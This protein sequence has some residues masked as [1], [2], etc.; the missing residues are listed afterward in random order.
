M[1]K[2][3][4]H[5]I[6]RLNPNAQ[7]GIKI[8]DVLKISG[9]PST[10]SSSSSETH[11]VKQKE[12]L[13]G[14]A[15]SHNLSVEELRELNPSVGEGLKTGQ[16]LIVRKRA[17]TTSAATHSTKTVKNSNSISHKVEARETKF[18]IAKQYGISVEEL[19]RQNPAIRQSLPVGY[20]LTIAGAKDTNEVI[21]DKYEV[22][23]TTIKQ[24]FANYEVKP[25]E[26]IYSLT[27]TLGISE[28]EL[29]RLN[30]SL[31]EGL[32][33]GMILKVPGKGSILVATSGKGFKDLSKSLS[34]D[35]RRK[36]AMLL[37]FNVSKI[38][39][40]S[41]KSVAE[42][43]KS[44]AFLNMTLDFYS[45]ALM[46]IDSAKT[47]GLKVDVHI[48]DSGESRASSNV[49]EVIRNNNINTFD[50]VIGPFYQEHAERAAQLLARD[51]V[52][53]ISP[54]S[55][56]KGESIS[57]LYQAMPPGDYSKTAIFE[58]MLSKGGNIVVVSAAKRESNREF[59][60]TNF[61]EAVFSPLDANGN[62]IPDKLKALL[63]K[64]KMNYVVLDSEKTG[65]ILSTTNV[66]LNELANYKIQL[67]I[68]EQNETLDF[69]EISMK[70]LTIL[71]MLYPSLIRE[72]TSHEALQFD[73][74]Y[75]RENKIFP[76]QYAI[77]GF[78]VTFDTLLRLSQEKSFEA[79][80]NE[81]QTEQI[82]SKFNYSKNGAEGYINKGVYILQFEEDLSVTEAK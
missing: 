1:Y 72:N 51:S 57:N 20:E 15:K 36:L 23:T 31:K 65:M 47:L 58:Y 33:E 11:T 10:A 19:E 17:G 40:D 55:K 78:D 59:I 81:D 9:E 41:A 13:Y 30:P 71:K 25:K 67:V 80:A 62:L 8:G 21:A 66:L 39:G 14:I 12:T 7:Q 52:A 26:T 29:I 38:E 18:G 64:D 22:T 32:K 4:P 68:M 42:R 48:Y 54:L 27:Q 44:D 56:D 73:N 70:R 82:E 6:Y 24:G 43:L 61:K 53:V 76:S 35:K 77:R 37:P 2:I 28:D 50:A 60:K 46:A 74:A 69:E 16:V 79:T 5:E 75:K 34:F 63:V 3:T 49:A 45:G